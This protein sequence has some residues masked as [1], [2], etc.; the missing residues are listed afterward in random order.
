MRVAVGRA[1][2]GAIINLTRRR[3]LSKATL[4]DH[5]TSRPSFADR[6]DTTYSDDLI[7]FAS[8]ADVLVHEGMY[9]P[10]REKMM[11]TIDNAP[12]RLDHRMKS[13]TTT[14]PLGRVAAAAARQP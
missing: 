1:V 5:D 7:A 8:G 14:G 4:V 10:A 9:L 11:A 12:T 3:T 2:Q 13:R 6:F